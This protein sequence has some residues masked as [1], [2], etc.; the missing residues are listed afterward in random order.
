MVDIVRQKT[1]FIRF[2]S[3]GFSSR[4][5]FLSSNFTSERV[6]KI[7]FSEQP[8]GLLLLKTLV[9]R[10]VVPISNTLTVNFI[11]DW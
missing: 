5:N 7:I 8:H 11:V 9:T 10:D 4:V 3:H 1:R 2:P 6:I